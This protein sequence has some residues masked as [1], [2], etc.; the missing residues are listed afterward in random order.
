MGNYR[1]DFHHSFPKQWVVIKPSKSN[2]EEVMIII[3]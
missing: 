1:L 2:A 3:T